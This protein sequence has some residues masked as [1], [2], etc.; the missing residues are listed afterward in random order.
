[1]PSQDEP[2]DWA[3]HGAAEGRGDLSRGDDHQR[4]SRPGEGRDEGGRHGRGAGEGKK[5]R[6]F[7]DFL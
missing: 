6:L 4:H 1:M 2:R 7:I 3:P 5:R